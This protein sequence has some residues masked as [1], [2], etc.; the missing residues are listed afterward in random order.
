MEV[1][2]E[3]IYIPAPIRCGLEELRQLP[4]VYAHWRQS[5]TLSWRWW[6]AGGERL[7]CANCDEYAILVSVL[8][9]RLDLNAFV[10]VGIVADVVVGGQGFRFHLAS[11]MLCLSPVYQPGFVSE[12][13]FLASPFHITIMFMSHLEG[14]NTWGAPTHPCDCS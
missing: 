7:V 12:S 3:G 6:S 14:G 1:M 4:S 11:G 9:S 10:N 5:G 13:C 8:S 2:E